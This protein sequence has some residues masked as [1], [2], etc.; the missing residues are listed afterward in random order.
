MQLFNR[1]LLDNQDSRNF[2]HELN[3][4]F[5]NSFEINLFYLK[6]IVNKLKYLIKT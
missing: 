4:Y 6:N 5:I 3:N 1:Y 2:E